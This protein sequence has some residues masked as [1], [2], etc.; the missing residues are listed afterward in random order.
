M[1][2]ELPLFDRFL[3]TVWLPAAMTVMVNLAAVQPCAFAQQ[4]TAHPAASTNADL[5]RPTTNDAAASNAIRR[6]QIL[7]SDRWKRV[8]HEFA[9]WLAVQVVCTPEQAERM[10]AKLQAE[11]QTMSAPELEQFLDQ[12]DAKLKILLGGN[13]AEARQWLAAN[14][15]VIAEGYRPQ[16]LKRLGITTDVTNL[17]AAQIEEELD[18]LRADRMEFE[19]QHAFFNTSR[20]FWADRS[21]Q[22]QTASSTSLQQAGQGTAGQYDSFQS[23]YSPRQYNYQPLPPIVPFFW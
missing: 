14:L 20:Q 8:E 11:I 17:T 3:F 6:N 19:Q 9:Q 12:W 13:A 22:W 16:F 1:L 10:K 21:R 15:S 23:P 2:M 5:G 7:A 18:R 4:S